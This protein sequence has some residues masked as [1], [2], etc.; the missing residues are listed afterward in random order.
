MASRTIQARMD[1][2]LKKKTGLPMQELKS[3]IERAT[4]SKESALKDRDH[5]LS[6]N[7]TMFHE[8]HI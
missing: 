2:L 4:A 6:S 3:I 8:C 5:T 7:Y 1:S